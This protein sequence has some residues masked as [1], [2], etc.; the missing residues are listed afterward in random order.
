MSSVMV[1]I[2]KVDVIDNGDGDGERLN[3]VVSVG[4]E[5]DGKPNQN[6]V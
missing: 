3:T 4:G 5:A 1:V 6:V 2:R